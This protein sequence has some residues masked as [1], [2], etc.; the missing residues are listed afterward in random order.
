[1]AIE[2]IAAIAHKIQG[3]IIKSDY[4]PRFLRTSSQNA[5]ASG[6][7]EVANEQST[8]AEDIRA[9]HDGHQDPQAHSHA[10]EESGVEGG[11]ADYP[12]TREPSVRRYSDDSDEINEHYENNIQRHED[13]VEDVY[14][15]EEALRAQKYIEFVPEELE[16]DY[17]QG[18]CRYVFIDDGVKDSAALMVPFKMSQ[19][20]KG[21]IKLQR[22]HKKMERYI[23]K[24]LAEMR[25]FRETLDIEIRSHELKLKGDADLNI[26]PSEEEAKR[27][28]GELEV[29]QEMCENLGP[30]ERELRTRLET[31]KDYLIEAHSAVMVHL[32]EAYVVAALAEESN[33]EEMPIERFD[34]QEQY[35]KFFA[36]RQ[37]NLQP[38]EVHPVAPPP[39]LDTSQ[40]TLMNKP[41]TP[42]PEEQ[43]TQD[44]RKRLRLAGDRLNTAQKEFHFKEYNQWQEKEFNRERT[45][46]GLEPIDVDKEAFD[47]RWFVRNHEITHELLEAEDDLRSARKAAIE[48][49]VEI[50]SVAPDE[51][52]SGIYPNHRSDGRCGS[53]S[54][55][56]SLAGPRVPSTSANPKVLEWLESRVE[57]SEFEAVD[58]SPKQP[59]EVLVLND[60]M[61]ME[62]ETW[63][64]QSMLDSWPYRRKLVK[65]WQQ[66]CSAEREQLA[67]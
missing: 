17:T 7:T 67:V 39:A 59:E 26:K 62:I 38:D 32:D 21:A 58:Q 36:Q 53:G 22:H 28:Q 20:I 24:Q 66:T 9:Q 61:A 13:A 60:A 3:R 30:R 1:M 6:A 31:I 16:Q 50:I 27:L 55:L 49:D 48:A 54:D 23:R 18:P 29:L 57:E 5:S 42:T 44:R 37:K 33:E 41:P 12:E 65:Q 2:D 15:A 46:E 45:L 63:D 47:R 52:W 56:S 34:L 10:A 43:F 14:A 64:S 8:G 35:Q 11:P 19:N 4:L 40:N 25:D 51:Y